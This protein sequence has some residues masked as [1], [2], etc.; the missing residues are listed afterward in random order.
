MGT[1]DK[2]ILRF[3]SKPKDFTF[4]ELRRLFQ[5]FGYLEE[6]GSGSRVV[7][8]NSVSNHKIKLHK[9]HPGNILKRYQMDLIEQELL[10]KN[11]L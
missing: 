6:Q 5:G 9:P 3:R 1:K 7:F 11:L 4:G 2:L 10:N 8:I